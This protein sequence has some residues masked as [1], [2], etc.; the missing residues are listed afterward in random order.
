M[1]RNCIYILYFKIPQYAIKR[2]NCVLVYSI[3][4]VFENRL[5]NLRAR[6]V[7]PLNESASR[8]SG[9]LWL[10]PVTYINPQTQSGDHTITQSYTAQQPPMGSG[11]K[12][13][14]SALSNLSM[15]DKHNDVV[16][17]NTKNNKEK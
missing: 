10:E 4:K 16:I 6:F 14:K 13:I 17:V 2:L 5:R 8:K 7:V 1:K 9:H 3:L 11:F 12:Y 15:G